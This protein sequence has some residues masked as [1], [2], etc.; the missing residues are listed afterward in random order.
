MQNE[1]VLANRILAHEGIV[2]AYGHVSLR[3]D[4]GDSFLLAWSRSAAF[5]E[6]GDL[7]EYDFAGTALREDSRPAYV[8]RMIHAAIY[9]GRSDVGAVVHSHAPNLLPFSI[10]DRPLRPVIHVAGMIGPHVPVW[11][12]A[13][14]FGDTDMLVR[15]L[16][17]GEDLARGLGA[18]SCALM[19]GHGAVI[20][21]RSLKEAVL[22]AVFL[23]LNAAT[24]LQAE[25]LGPYRALSDGEAELSAQAH[26]A[27]HVLDRAWDYFAARAVGS[28]ATS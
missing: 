5:V 2:D 9:A 11:D 28:G 25:A 27:G 21:G 4:G 15:T 3:C 23:H 1:L 24:Q 6:A 22:R 16:S 13:D 7:V 17:Q 12:I 18:H 19:R 26:S 14:R 20:V 8:E 10:S